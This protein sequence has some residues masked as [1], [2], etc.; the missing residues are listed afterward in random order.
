MLPVWICILHLD[1]SNRPG[2]LARVSLA[3]AD[4]GISLD[5]VLAV[6][7]GERPQIVVK[8]AASERLAEYFRRRFARMPMV[9]EVEIRPGGNARVWDVVKQ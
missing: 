3:F 4:R 9:T 1:H 6:G 5:E 2:V 7:V 8:F